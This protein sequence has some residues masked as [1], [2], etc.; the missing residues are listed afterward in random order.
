MLDGDVLNRGADSLRIT[1]RIASRSDL[2]IILGQVR[3]TE[4]P[5]TRYVQRYE[6]KTKGTGA[7]GGR[8]S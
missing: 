2:P 3:A 4:R 8:H 6:S 5:A 7:N 1:Q